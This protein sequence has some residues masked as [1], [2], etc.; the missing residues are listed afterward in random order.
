M[1]HIELEPDGDL[2]LEIGSD[3][4]KDKAIVNVKPA[5]SAQEPPPKRQRVFKGYSILVSGRT[6]AKASPVHR[7]MLTEPS[8]IKCDSKIMYLPEDNPEVMLLIL[9]IAHVEFRKI[10]SALDLDTLYQIAVVSDKYDCV[11]FLQPWIKGWLEPHDLTSSKIAGNAFICWAFGK[12]RAFE[13]S[14]ERLIVNTVHAEH[15]DSAKP[16]SHVLKRVSGPPLA[17]EM[18]PPGALGE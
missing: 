16:K 8:G 13:A 7:T 2:T 15:L 18:W 1:E 10:P 9:R 14:I 5:E 3:Y 4:A 6:V 11:E 17:Q 12:E